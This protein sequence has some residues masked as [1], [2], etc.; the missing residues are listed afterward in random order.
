[1]ENMG[2]LHMASMLH[3]TVRMK[4]FH[5]YISRN[6]YKIIK[7]LYYGYKIIKQNIIKQISGL[8]TSIITELML[9]MMRSGERIAQ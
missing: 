9:M 3:I 6:Y 5:N 1:M 8:D 2:A 4:F 7:K